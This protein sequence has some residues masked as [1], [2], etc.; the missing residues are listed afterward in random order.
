LRGYSTAL[1][2]GYRDDGFDDVNSSIKEL[3]LLYLFSLSGMHDAGNG[4]WA[5]SAGISAAA[6]WRGQYQ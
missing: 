3:G 6:K 2:V 5:Y 4:A 1:I